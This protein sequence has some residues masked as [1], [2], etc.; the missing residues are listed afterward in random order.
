MKK[1]KL[2][3]IAL[4]LAAQGMLL[5]QTADLPSGVGTSTDPYQVETLNNLYWISQN[6]TS[7]DKYFEQTADIDA[8]TTSGWDGG[9]GFLPIGNSIT[10]F[11]GSYNGQGGTVAGLTINRPTTTFVGL[12]GFAVGGEVKNIGVTT[13]SITG[14]YF[15]GGIVGYVLNSTDIANCF[16]SGSVTGNYFVGGLTGFLDDGSL[17]DNCGSTASVSGNRYVGGLSGRNLASVSDC[18][19]AG[20]VSGTSYTGGLAG[21][22]AGTATNSFY[23][24]QTTGQ[25]TSA[26]GTGKTTAEMKDIATYTSLATSGLTTAWDFVG[27]END[28]SGILDWWN[29]DTTYNSGY[30]VPS[31]DDFTIAP[32]GTGSEADPYQIATLNNLYWFTE[33]WSNS[34]IE[35]L[36]DI[37]AY[38]TA[39][40]RFGLGF[41]PIADGG[42]FNGHYNGNGYSI[43]GLTMVNRTTFKIGFIGHLAGTV[44]DLSIVDA[45]FRDESESIS[46]IGVLAGHIQNGSVA[47]CFASGTINITGSGTTGCGMLVGMNGGTITECGA[48][49]TISV[50]DNGLHLGGLIGY[51]WPWYPFEVSNC[52]S[53]VDIDGNGQTSCIGGFCGCVHDHFFHVLLENCYSS[54]SVTGI[55]P[56]YPDNIGGFIGNNG[57]EEITFTACFWDTENSG[58]TDGVGNMDPDPAGVTGKPLPK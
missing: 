17:L 51:I 4:V 36:A 20:S 57:T 9:A 33:N 8:A 24:T 54:G 53:S 23:D 25:T 58:T 37:Y 39:Y 38:S 21:D 10:A 32:A 48:S 35:Q 15:V 47:R 5:A 30:P 27:E 29:M 45:D 28:D 22:G 18:Y 49:G 16:S 55:D 11:T 56:A 26:G 42:E 14:N 43:K 1:I 7:W 31:W 34:Y 46:F 13:A 50:T 52:Y 44:S 41:K 2:F 19:A 6:D 40:I 3:T 12:F